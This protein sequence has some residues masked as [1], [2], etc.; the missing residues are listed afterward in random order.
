[1]ARYGSGYKQRDMVHVGFRSGRTSGDYGRCYL[2]CAKFCFGLDEDIDIRIVHGGNRCYTGIS[3]FRFDVYVV[4]RRYERDSHG[5]KIYVCECHRGKYRLGGADYRQA[6]QL[7][8]AIASVSDKH[9]NTNKRKE[10]R[11]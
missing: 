8:F 5:K 9:K 11:I 4:G 7:S 2:G 6:D 1:M 3:H 10:V